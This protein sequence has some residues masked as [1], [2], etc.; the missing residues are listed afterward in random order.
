[1][2]WETSKTTCVDD[3]SLGW[4]STSVPQ[5]IML[6]LG[7]DLMLM[8]PIP[9]VVL[10]SI[11]PEGCYIVRNRVSISWGPWIDRLPQQINLLL[12]CLS[13]NF[14]AR[15]TLLTKKTITSTQTKHL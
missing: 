15:T 1:M 4:P 8:R 9:Q 10:L 12:G 7:T 5:L 2:S 3:T 14:L 13:A 6:E 11:Q